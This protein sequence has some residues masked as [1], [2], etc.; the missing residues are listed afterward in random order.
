MAKLGRK[1]SLSLEDERQLGKALAV[2]GV[3]EQAALQIWNIAREGCGPQA[4]ESAFK[5][6]QKE[7]L[8]EPLNC[9]EEV[10]LPGFHGE[11]VLWVPRLATLLQW[12]VQVCEAWAS[13]LKMVHRL[14]DGL[15]TPIYYHDEITCGNILAVIK[16]K[17]ITAYYLS[18]REMRGHLYKELAWLPICVIQHLQCDRIKG[19]LSAVTRAILR[20]CHTDVTQRDMAIKIGTEHYMFRMALRGHFVSDQDAQRGTWCTKGSSGLKP[21]QFCSNVVKKNCLDGSDRFHSIASASFASFSSV[22]DEDWRTAHAHLETLSPKE[23]HA[24]EKAYGLN[25]EP[26]GLLNDAAAFA[27]LPPSAAANDSMHCYFCNGVASA[28]V[29]RVVQALEQSGVKLQQL[30]QMAVNSGWQ[31]VGQA[32]KTKIERILADKMFEGETYKG[33]AD[34]TRGAVYLLQYYLAEILQDSDQMIPERASFHALKICCVHL[35]D[36]HLNWQAPSAVEEVRPLHEAQL[37]H[38]RRFVDAYG[39]DAVKPKHHHRLHIPTAVL[40]LGVLPNCAVQESKHRVMKGA[41][42]VDRQVGKLNEASQLQK[43][44]LP[45]LLMTVAESANN[46]GLATWA[47]SEPS[48]PADQ[49]L[50]QSLN[51]SSLKASKKAEL[52]QISIMQ[53]DVIFWAESAGQVLCCLFGDETGMLL[54]MRPL[55]LIKRASW[56]SAWKQ[57]QAETFCLRMRVSHQI[58]RPTWVR[59]DSNCVICLH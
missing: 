28:E 33:D 8:T 36:L 59:E 12:I 10:K 48:K 7:R 19:G 38:Q 31:K 13:A 11:E 21:C 22:P 26:Y 49:L 51:D 45:R 57:I 43:S 16:K 24:W 35:H 50:R 55:Q 52:L 6:V 39:A 42:L 47:L 5:R 32:S 41:K 3:A 40:Q 25:Y 30:R 54:H 9:F 15:L 14:R 56:G 20:A 53:N 29:F 23:R 58:H 17:K 2:P 27:A 37:E 46:H 1:R 34:D 44:L 4:K 18:F